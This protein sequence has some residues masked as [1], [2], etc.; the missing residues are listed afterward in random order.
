MPGK[1]IAIAAAVLFAV[2]LSGP[3]A[4]GAAPQGFSTGLRAGGGIELAASD[5][6]PLKAQPAGNAGPFVEVQLGRWVG[7][8]LA[9]QPHVTGPSDLSEG[10]QYRGHWGTDL[11]PY[12]SVRWLESSASESLE[13]VAGNLVGGIV[14]YDRYFLTCRYFFYLGVSVEP[15][16]ELHFRQGTGRSRHSLVT[17]LPLDLYFRRDLSFSAATGVAVAWKL[18]VPRAAQGAGP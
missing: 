12:L 8:G 13:L 7:L 5:P 14:R 6:F 3:A 18:Y 15:Y 16:L 11:R 10:F 9:A 2:S 1:T 17:S 4:L